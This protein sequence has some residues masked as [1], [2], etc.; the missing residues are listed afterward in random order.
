MRSKKPL[1]HKSN[2]SRVFQWLLDHGFTEHGTER[3]RERMRED[4][5]NHPGES[6]FDCSVRIHE[7]HYLVWFDNLKHFGLA[8][9]NDQNKKGPAGTLERWKINIIPVPV[10]DVPTAKRVIR[11]NTNEKL[12]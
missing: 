12:W 2:Y 8:V 6:D 10:Y 9:L 1:G 11:G 7:I 3:S 5:R 4:P